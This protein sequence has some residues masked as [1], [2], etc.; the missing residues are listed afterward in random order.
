MEIFVSFKT[1]LDYSFMGLKPAVL[2]TH[3]LGCYSFFPSS[4][5]IHRCCLYEINDTFL[6]Q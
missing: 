2:Q 6:L 4:T 3:N 1:G 5:Q